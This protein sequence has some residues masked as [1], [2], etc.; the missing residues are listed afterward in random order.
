MK[1]KPSN[2]AKFDRCVKAVK[3]R[4]GAVSPYAVCKKSVG[5]KG[6]K[7][8]KRNPAGESADAFQEFHGYPSEQ[9]VTVSKKIHYHEHLAAVGKLEKLIVIA[10]ETGDRVVLEGFQGAVLAFNE[11]RTQ[12]F[13]EGGDQKVNVR[14]FGITK[15]HE[16]EY[17][18]DVIVVEYFAR[19]DHL[20]KDGGVATYVHKFKRPYPA[21][22]Y[23]SRNE[24][25]SFAGG[26][27][28]I[29][30]EGIDN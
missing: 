4:G 21:L 7:K 22:M 15:H 26:Q 27:Y 23:D 6:K 17:L 16:S 12:L 25:L 11:K 24:Q 1:R 9:V 8:G 20:G 18:G 13:I 14:E 19:K 29:L 30:T 28:D 5:N 2:P 10:R 3:K